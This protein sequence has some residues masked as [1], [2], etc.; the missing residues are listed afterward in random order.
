M[1]YATNALPH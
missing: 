1:N